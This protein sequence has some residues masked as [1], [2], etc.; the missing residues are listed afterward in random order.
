MSWSPPLTG[1]TEEAVH[2]Y[3]VECTTSTQLHSVHLSVDNDT[4]I[5]KLDHLLPTSSYNCCVEVFFESYS[6]RACVSLNT[7][8]V[9][10][11]GSNRGANTVGGVL[12]FI[13]VVLVILLVLAGIILMYPRVIE[14]RIKDNVFFSRYV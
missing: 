3:E 4:H 5:A 13:I 7:G 14:P 9:E 2:S 8:A 12:G 1:T 10:A 11:L 6:S